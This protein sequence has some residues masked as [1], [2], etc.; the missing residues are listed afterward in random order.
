MWLLGVTTCACSKNPIT[1]LNSFYNHYKEVTI[2]YSCIQQTSE[3]F[4]FSSRNFNSRF[5]ENLI[6]YNCLSFVRPQTRLRCTEAKAE[7]TSTKRSAWCNM[8][9]RRP[10][11]RRVGGQM[12]E[13]HRVVATQRRSRE[14]PCN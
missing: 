6:I 10:Q 3:S 5:S 14:G 2:C 1:N 13:V 4:H 9:R 8:K 11:H 12:F 7:L